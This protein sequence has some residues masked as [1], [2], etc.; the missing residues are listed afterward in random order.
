MD[1]HECS[2]C[3]KD[4]AP[5]S[6]SYILEL[7]ILA[8]YD[9]TV[10]EEDEYLLDRVVEEL[11]SVVKREMEDQIFFEESFT[12]CPVCRKDVIKM[13]AGFTGRSKDKSKESSVPQD[14]GSTLH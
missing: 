12:L 14:N 8:G 1:S 2:R 11:G 5:G 6:T 10:K 7:R 3:L 4:L 9:G 13:V